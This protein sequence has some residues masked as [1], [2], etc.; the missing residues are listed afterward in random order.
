M[1]RKRAANFMKPRVGF[2]FFIIDNGIIL[3]LSIYVMISP[4]I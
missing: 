4:A 3:L 1:K 2:V